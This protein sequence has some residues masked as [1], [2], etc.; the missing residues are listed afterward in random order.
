MSEKHDENDEGQRYAIGAV[1][2]LTGL[3]THTIRIW[4]RRYQAVV[5]ERSANG[6]RQYA[7]EDVEKLCLLKQL[8]DE[9]IAISKIAAEDIP[10]L[11]GRASEI[12][13]LGTNTL[14]GRIAMAVLGEELPSRM[15]KAD[16]ELHPIDIVVADHDEARFLA[17][18]AR[19]E[20]D[21]V[22]M[23]VPVIDDETTS[24]LLRL[25]EDAGAARG[26]LVYN[27]STTRHADGA[28]RAGILTLRAPVDIED[29]RAA[30]SR[31]VAEAR[32]P[33]GRQ[34][35]KPMQH[36]GARWQ[37]DSEIPRRRFDRRQLSRLAGAS[38]TI[39]CE[40]PHHLAQLV[41]D[42]SAFEIY[43]AQCANR[44]DEDAALHGYLHQT[45]A[46]ARSL[47]EIALERV[48]EAE[49]LDY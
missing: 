9:G 26:V 36:D 8:T 32:V 41:S 24:D 4:E 1:A 20:V 35:E 18:L 38:T 44:D 47:I 19:N 5:A 10:A 3:S 46:Q 42:L 14:T 48:A 33:R 28:R 43:S 34:R 29:V 7:P 30:A 21:I 13:G 16:N 27:F 15:L 11:R 31:A 39:D 40:C 17:D 2:K 23:E 49:G 37:F 12:D 22:L 45:T 6:R 25:V